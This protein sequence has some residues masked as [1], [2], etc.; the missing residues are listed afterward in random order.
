VSFSIV[1]ARGVFVAQPAHIGD[2]IL[3]GDLADLLIPD[4]FEPLGEQA[5]V[6]ADCTQHPA[7]GC[8]E[9]DEAGNGLA[10]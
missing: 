5:L 1:A 9:V 7:F 6:G 8:F 2:Y 3:G 10:Q 4:G